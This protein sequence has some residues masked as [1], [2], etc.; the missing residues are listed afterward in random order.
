[1]NRRTVAAMVVVASLV[2][3]GIPIMMS[4]QPPGDLGAVTEPSTS[5]PGS[6]ASEAASSSP[7]SSQSDRPSPLASPAEDTA[8]SAGLAEDFDRLVTGEGV[9]GW[10]VDGDARL[11]VAALPTAVQRSA[12]LET[13]S[14]GMACRPLP[15]GMQRLSAVFMLDALPPAE[16]LTLALATEGGQNVSLAISPDG[17]SS[18]SGTP[19]PAAIQ[20]DTW[21]RWSVVTVSGAVTTSLLDAEGNVL[22]EHAVAGED[23]VGNSFCLSTRAPARVHLDSLTVENP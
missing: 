11:E 4:D 5:S 9:P 12:R 3:A 7:I 8:G 19:T 2:G 20:A 1:M 17:R 13:D 10:E 22:A 16:I 18:L 15:P 14:D 6:R 21:Y 23:A